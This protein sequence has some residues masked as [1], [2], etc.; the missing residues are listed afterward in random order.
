MLAS[1]F[2]SNML[3]V[4]VVTF[5]WLSGLAMTLFC[6]IFYFVRRYLTASSDMQKSSEILQQRTSELGVPAASVRKTTV[7]PKA[8]SYISLLVQKSTDFISIA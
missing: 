6:A 8:L 5:V 2:A 3:T 7:S 1:F 4:V